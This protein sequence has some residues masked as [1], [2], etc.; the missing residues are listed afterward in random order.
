MPVRRFRSVA[1]MEQ[2]HWRE[3]GD[4]ELFKAIA[5]L[6]TTGARTVGLRFPP[7]VYR[8]RTIEALNAQTEDWAQANFRAFQASRVSLQTRR[9]QPD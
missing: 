4:P 8:H 6:W 7:G 1:D 2:P 5:A 3:P 9:D